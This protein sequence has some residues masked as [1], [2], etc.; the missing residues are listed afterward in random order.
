MSIKVNLR[1]LAIITILAMNMTH[2]SHSAELNSDTIFGHGEIDFHQELGR[3]IRVG[4]WSIDQE[5]T[6]DL[7]IFDQGEKIDFFFKPNHI[8]EYDTIIMSFKDEVILRN[9]SID[10]FNSIGLNKEEILKSNVMSNG[11]F[12]L[13][14]FI[15]NVENG[16]KNLRVIVFIEEKIEYGANNICRIPFYYYLINHNDINKMANEDTE[17]T[18]F[19]EICEKIE[20]MQ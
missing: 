17:I 9:T 5:T 4:F 16:P 19:A 7:R 14:N 20:R 13:Y 12:A 10:Q 2:I 8:Y 18:G 1:A 15:A 11:N 6:N 3:K